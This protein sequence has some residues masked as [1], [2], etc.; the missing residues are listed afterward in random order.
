MQVTVT[1]ATATRQVL[2]VAHDTVTPVTVTRMTRTNSLSD[3][4]NERI[5]KILRALIDRDTSGNIT[6]FAKR[7]DVTGPGLN[8]FLSGKRGAG[9]KLLTAIAD[10]TGR[11]MDDLMGRPSAEV[12][13]RLEGAVYGNLEGWPAAAAEAKRRKIVPDDAI[14]A[15]ARIGGL[16]P[17]TGDVSPEFVIDVAQFVARHGMHLAA[18]Q[19]AAMREELEI[20]REIKR[21]ESRAKKPTS[22]K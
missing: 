21:M 7:L 8:E 16:T 10:Y 13:H 15:A 9:G 19:A 17:P 14:D 11:T 1:P 5:R 4:A 3:D 18:N 6:H 12:P 22:R 20:R 2:K